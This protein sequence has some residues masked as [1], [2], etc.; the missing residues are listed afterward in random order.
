VIV[1]APTA[2]IDKVLAKHQHVSDLVANRWIHLF[3]MGKDGRV[4]GCSDGRGGW[5]NL[6]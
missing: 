6:Y 2:S 3:V 4:T 1:E 5:R